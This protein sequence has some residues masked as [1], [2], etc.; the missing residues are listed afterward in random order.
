M[1]FIGIYTPARGPFVALNPVEWWTTPT[2]FTS[3]ALS[4]WLGLPVEQKYF[5]SKGKTFMLSFVVHG[6]L[7]L[8]RLDHITLISR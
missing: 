8:W 6:K 7:D 3:P 4:S 1:K 5:K 2:P